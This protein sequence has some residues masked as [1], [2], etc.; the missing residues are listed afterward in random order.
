MSI[1]GSLKNALGINIT[2]KKNDKIETSKVLSTAEDG[3]T[4]IDSI[5]PSFIN[6]AINTDFVFDD[7]IALIKK[8][9]D[10]SLNVDCDRAIDNI[11]NEI[12]NVE[13]GNYDPIT[14]NL[15]RL[16]EKYDGIKEDLQKAFE[17]ILKLLNF[18][19]NGQQIVRDWYIDGRLFFQKVVDKNALDKGIIDLRRIDALDIKKIKQVEK[20]VDPATGALIIDN[21]VTYYLYSPLYESSNLTG[22]A[23]LL[24]QD[25]IAYA[26]SGLYAYKEEP[27]NKNTTSRVG[28]NGNKFII[29]YL[30]PAIK[31]LNQ[32]SVLEDATI[33][34][35]VSRSSEKRVHYIDI[36]GLPK[37]KAEAAMKEYVKAFTNQV[38]YNTKTGEINSDSKVSSL[39]EDIFVPR[40]GGTNTAEIST[41]PA[42]QNLGEIEDVNYFKIRLY[43]AL[44]VPLSRLNDD[45]PSFLGRANEIS[46]DELNFSKHISNI[47]RNLNDM[48]IDLLKTQALLKNIVSLSDWNKI[49]QDIEFEY[50]SNTYIS[51][52]REIDMLSEKLSALR[53]ADTYVGKYFSKNYINK[54]ILGFTDEQV[55]TIKE[56]NAEDTEAEPSIDTPSDNSQYF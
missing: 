27:S 50:S 51:R 14:L 28:T 21:E 9:R 29:S 22:Q 54:N 34:Y 43:K 23:V 19:N 31:P 8:Y 4:I 39:Q 2:P 13:D 3:S 33:I 1:L 55:A 16:D 30:H 56:E 36:N 5:G 7:D 45:T 44:K 11:V 15:D 6:R 24:T 53:E 42:A 49:S 12:I 46:R 41:L 35:R 32:L 20:I 47:R 52:L 26:H 37:S 17:K 48:W 38:Q 25:S 40:R 18:K 10:M